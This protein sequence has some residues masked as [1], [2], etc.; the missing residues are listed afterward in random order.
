V[1]N[2]ITNCRANRGMIGIYRVPQRLTTA[3]FLL[4]RCPRGRRNEPQETKRSSAL[5]STYRIRSINGPL[6]SICPETRRLIATFPPGRTPRPWQPI[7]SPATTQPAQFCSKM[8][9]LQACPGDASGCAKM[10]AS[11]AAGR[12][13]ERVADRPPQHGRPRRRPTL[14]LLCPNR[15][16]RRSCNICRDCWKFFQASDPE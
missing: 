14:G 13:A 3:R 5:R 11:A 1:H 12:T 8:E 4:R 9:R 2:T 16:L 7:G 6:R 10:L 15:P